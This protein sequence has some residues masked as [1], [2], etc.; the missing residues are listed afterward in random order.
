MINYL[1]R[2]WKIVS[3]QLSIDPYYLDELQTLNSL[4][5]DQILVVDHCN[6]KHYTNRCDI[7]SGN[8]FGYP[9]LL[10]QSTFCLIF[11]GQRMGQFL[12]LEAMAA[13]CI[14]VIVMDGYVMPFH[15][16]IGMYVISVNEKDFKVT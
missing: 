15:D 7:I 4:H 2:T 13:N 5:H 11:H 14:P 10:K 3:S 16:V 8:I 1:F 6:G 12:L 9:Q